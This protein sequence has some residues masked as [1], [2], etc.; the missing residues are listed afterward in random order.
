[1]AMSMLWNGQE[2]QAIA[3]LKALRERAPGDRDIAWSLANALNFAGLN[4][5]AVAAFLEQTP[6]VQ[7]G[8]RADL[9]RAWR[10]AGYEEKA[11]PLLAEPSDKEGRFLRDWRV[12]RELARFGYTSVERSEDRDKLTTD[13]LVFG[14]GWH[15][16]PGATADFQLRR[17][18]LDDPNGHPDATQFQ[19]SYR[20]RI[21]EIGNGWGTMWPMVALRVS[22]FPGWTPVQ[23]TARLTWIPR[24]RL[25]LDGEITR[26]VVEAPLAVRNR[27][28][29]DTLSAGAEYRPNSLWMLAGTTSVL[30]FDD[31][32][33]RSRVNG[34]VERSV[35]AFPRV[36]LGLEG[37]AFNRVVEGTNADNRGYWNP[38]R[39]AEARAYVT[40]IHDMWP[41]DVVARL[42]YG[43]SREVDSLGNAS[44]SHPNLW[45]LTLGW[46][47]T[48]GLRLTLAA[49]G[50]G[51]SMGG[52]SGSGTGYWR[53]F[54][55]LGA[56]VWF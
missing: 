32:T 20:W 29:V 38:R 23:P 42:G 34:R 24:D 35:H 8:E 31:G 7:P 17:L 12:W 56:N 19:A 15:P 9:A 3:E 10:W 25:R 30:R 26:E 4:R 47:V 27:V 33:T 36:L 43:V 18:R 50:S 54:V 6:P 5:E 28:T 55:R 14:G 21:G 37:M 52:V 40:L 11:W 51:Q 39:Y 1:M 44:N 41:F 53:R 16:Q 48:P 49:G 46:D 22:D 45:E 13:V 2:E